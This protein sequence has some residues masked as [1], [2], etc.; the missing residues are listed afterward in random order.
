MCHR[1]PGGTK[2]SEDCIHQRNIH[3]V[4]YT[5][6]R[7]PTLGLNPCVLKPVLETLIDFIGY[8]GRWLVDHGFWRLS[9]ELF[10]SIK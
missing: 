2:G 6:L 4:I 5:V 1:C 3:S 7:C 9:S 8:S 10:S